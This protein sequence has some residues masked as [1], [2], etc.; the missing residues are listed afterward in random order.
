MT[1]IQEQ[2]LKAG[3]VDQDKAKRVSKEKHKLKK[4]ARKTRGKKSTPEQSSA[5]AMKARNAARDRDLNRQKQER[6][7][8]KAI[9]AQI[10]Q[11]IQMNRIDDYDGEIAYNFIYRNKVKTLHINDQI[12]KQIIAGR[13]AIVKQDTSNTSEFEIVANSVADKIAQR[14]KEYII[15]TVQAEIEDSHENAKEDDPYADFKVPDDLMW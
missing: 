6:A 9:D 4:S 7:D 8:S 5:N 13:L 3:L 11:L 1:S 15:H 2:L 10:R 12:Q 14:N